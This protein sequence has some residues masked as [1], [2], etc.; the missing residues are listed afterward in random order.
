[1][2]ILAEAEGVAL[3]HVRWCRRQGHS[4]DQILGAVGQRSILSPN[5]DGVVE[6]IA[7]L[8]LELVHQRHKTAA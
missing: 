6:V 3:E 2:D 8:W 5:E 1:M 4:L 7:R